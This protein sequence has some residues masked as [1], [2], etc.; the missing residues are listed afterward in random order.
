MG[1]I[2]L[3]KNC[4][5]YLYLLFPSRGLIVLFS[6]LF[7]SQK[8]FGIL[9]REPRTPNLNVRIYRYNICRSVDGRNNR[10][11]GKHKRGNPAPQISMLEYIDTLSAWGG[12]DLKVPSPIHLALIATLKFGGRGTGVL[13][14]VFDYFVHQRYEN[15][16]PLTVSILIY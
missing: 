14:K 3:A 9:K 2:L 7:Q 10:T 11:P 4:Y 5:L 15:W 8:L 1:D 13:C 16:A 6:P 12:F